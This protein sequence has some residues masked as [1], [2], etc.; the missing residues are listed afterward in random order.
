MDESKS[1]IDE[2]KLPFSGWWPV[3][4]GALA[5]LAVRI[6]FSGEPGSPYAA[7]TGSFIY[8]S[9]VI[10]GAVTV[11]A[12]ERRRRRTWGYYFGTACLANLLYV[13]GTVL[14]MVEGLICAV[15]IVPLF[16]VLGGLGGLIMG[17]VCRLTK[18]P[19]HTLYGMA[20]L[21]F[22]LG[23]TEG[24][25]P[26]PKRLDSVERSIV[27][28]AA[29]ERVWRELM[30]TE[31]IRPEEIQR[32]WLFRIGV[33]LALAGMAH[34]DGAQL[35]RRVTMGKQIY[36]D[37]VATDW[38]ENRRVRW[39]YRFHKDS[40]P[41]YALDEHVMIGGHY[42]DL[43]ETAYVLTPR[44]SA[45]ELKVTMQYRLSTR[46]NW[47]AEPV[48]RALFGNLEETNLEF[49]RRRSESTRP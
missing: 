22:M 16:T 25:L 31:S 42:F 6:G 12:A 46:F 3:L 41:P 7:M 18:W 26:L 33:P 49:Y 40:F 38:E 10:V 11:Y 9:P 27:I 8:L 2:R 30:R 43:R 48:A 24:G 45:T 14:V 47:Y 39:G 5:G 4:A 19:K 32:A 36:F 23:A 13:A 21:P 20:I 35:T 17:A 34:Q 15:V 44:G 28:D 29:P 37:Q 1:N